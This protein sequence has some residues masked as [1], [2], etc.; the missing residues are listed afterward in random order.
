[1]D[2]HQRP[3]VIGI[4][5]LGG[6][7]ACARREVF[8]AMKR[9][10]PPVKLAAVCEPDLEGHADAVDEL[11]GLGIHV[12]K[13]YKEMLKGKI[14]AVWL[15]VPIELHRPMTTQAL[16]AGKAVLCEK[17][18][19]GAVDDLQAM[20]AARDRAKLPCVVGYQDIYH[21]ATMLLKQCILNGQIGQV[22]SASV[23]AC[24]PRDDRY[25]GRNKWAGR[26]RRNGI[27]VLDSP[28]NN[29]L[30][31]YI[32]LTL[33]LL[34]PE[35]HVP[36]VPELVEAELYRARP[37][38]NYDTVSMRVTLKGGVAVLSLLTHA[39]TQTVDPVVQITGDC[40]MIRAYAS[41]HAEITTCRGTHTVSLLGGRQHMIERFAKL[42]RREPDDRAVATLES[43]R[44][45]LMVINGASE[46]TAVCDVPKEHVESVP[47]EHGS[48][49]HAAVGVEEA[50]VK[51]AREGRMLHESGRVPWSSP[52]GR[53]DLNGFRRFNGPM[54]A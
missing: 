8:E 9:P 1:M 26:I 31:H 52:G 22:K 42:V 43:A 47:L 39:C 2:L 33:F 38:E 14:E 4:A 41:D 6:Y 21:P 24:W 40:G 34:G 45:H 37:I 11:R 23:M 44:P 32:N 51:A 15:P 35:P 30:S 29:A 13:S 20:I 5:G 28:A 7:A 12:C 18:P 48:L 10:Q 53:R 36:A 19:A 49:V 17:P 50:F 46:A 54:T 3:V 16:A 27:W 25:W